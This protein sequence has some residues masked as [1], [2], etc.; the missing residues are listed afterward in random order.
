MRT[1]WTVYVLAVLVQEW[2]ILGVGLTDLVGGA[3]HERK[4]LVEVAVDLGVAY[5]VGLGFE[6]RVLWALLL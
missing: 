2:I 1:V 5:A 6:A 4:G 3:T